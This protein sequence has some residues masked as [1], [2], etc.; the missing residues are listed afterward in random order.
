MGLV[1][2]NTAQCAAEVDRLQRALTETQDGAEALRREHDKL[3]RMVHAVESAMAAQPLAPSDT[4]AG[5]GAEPTGAETRPLPTAAAAAALLLR[6]GL[7]LTEM[8]RP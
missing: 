6:E 8:V 4:P 7:S 2:T 1:C 3:Q 5:S